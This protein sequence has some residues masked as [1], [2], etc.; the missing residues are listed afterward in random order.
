MAQTLRT[1][2]SFNSHT[3]ARKLQL[4]AM[5]HASMNSIQGLLMCMQ[6][7]LAKAQREIL[8]PRQQV[9]DRILQEAARLH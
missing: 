9:I 6:Q 3:T 8:Q 4:P 1:T 5:N 2:F 7:Y